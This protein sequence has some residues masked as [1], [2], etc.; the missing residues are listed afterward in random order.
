MCM[1]LTRSAD[2]DITLA[3]LGLCS[4]KQIVAA[5][6]P[7]FIAATIELC[8]RSLVN[9]IRTVKDQALRDGNEEQVEQ[10]ISILDALTACVSSLH[11]RSHETLIHE[12]LTIPI[13]KACQVRPLSF[14]Y[15]TST[16]T[17]LAN[18]QRQCPVL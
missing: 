14:P 16:P 1:C 2:F 5:F 18:F 17:H 7:P 13:W 3:E 9:Q 8:T 11:E 15:I 12:L 6:L 10:L 4:P